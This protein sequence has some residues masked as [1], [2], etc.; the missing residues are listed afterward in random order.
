MI[1]YMSIII[2]LKNLFRISNIG[3]IIFFLLNALLLIAIFSG[4]D[5][6]RVF[7]IVIM[8]II[9]LLLSLSPIGEFFISCFAGA[10]VMRRTDMRNRMLPLVQRVYDKAREKTPSLPRSII[11]KVMYDS[12]PN[13]FAIGRKT[14]CVTEGLFDLTDDQIEG[15]LAHE[16]G[17]LALHHTLIQVL[18]GGGNIIITLFLLF[19]RLVQIIVSAIAALG[20]LL[21]RNCLIQLACLITGTLC[22]VFIWLWTKF[23]MLCFMWSS[24]ANEYEADKYAFELGYGN[25]LAEVLD[26]I[27]TGVPQESFFKALYSSHPDTHDR[28]GR[29][30]E[31]GATYTRY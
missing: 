25:E 5:S 11:L 28:I 7:F 13:A 29:L 2:F 21:S 12:S 24:R 20:G 1:H 4:G 9:S 30:Q 14:I 18:I 23:C 31:M 8:Y 17:H 22:Y 3:T 27:G 26:N 15:I 10:K 19:L 16:F 6:G